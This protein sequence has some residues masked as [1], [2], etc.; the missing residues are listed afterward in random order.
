MSLSPTTLVCFLEL[1]D[2]ATVDGAESIHHLADSSPFGSLKLWET[3]LSC[4]SGSK[5]RLETAGLCH[6]QPV[7]KLLTHLVTVSL[8]RHFNHPLFFHWAQ[9]STNAFQQITS[10]ITIT[11][12]LKWIHY[13]RQNVSTL[14]PGF[15]S[16]PNLVIL[17]FCPAMPTSQITLRVT[18]LHLVLVYVT[19][20]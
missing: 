20:D 19:L 16:L 5:M 6:H 4:V 18:C 3:Y 15:Q 10:P 12:N 11:K 7:T 9:L 14:L 13:Q 2:R 8:S 17:K 1:K